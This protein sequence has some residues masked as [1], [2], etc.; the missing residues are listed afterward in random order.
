M[1]TGKLPYHDGAEF[2]LGT[3]FGKALVNVMLI[4]VAEAAL[5]RSRA[6]RAKPDSSTVESSAMVSKV[7][8]SLPKD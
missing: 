5:H 6:A 2:L 1:S 3:D 7:F 8:E 4:D